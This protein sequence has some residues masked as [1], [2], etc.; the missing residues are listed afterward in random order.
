[1]LK[2]ILIVLCFLMLIG[3]TGCPKQ[4]NTNGYTFDKDNIIFN[5]KN[6]RINIDDYDYYD[7]DTTEQSMYPTIKKGS[8]GI[9]KRFNEDI[10]LNDGDIISFN[11]TQDGELLTYAHRIVKKGTDKQGDYFI[12]KGDNQ[13]FKDNNKV[14]YEDISHVFIGIIY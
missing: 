4:Y 9:A 14:R 1:M 2:K 8:L 7:F 13:W 11:V 10:E 5:Q 12:T 3:L 6:I